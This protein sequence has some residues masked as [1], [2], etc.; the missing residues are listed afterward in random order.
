MKFKNILLL[1]PLL[2]TLIA[3]NSCSSDS[4]HN[5]SDEKSSIYHIVTGVWIDA[6]N[7]DRVVEID[8]KGNAYHTRTL[9][10]KENFSGSL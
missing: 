6:D 10:V 8:E 4:D 7:T 1:I 5:S 2:L 9:Q 3:I